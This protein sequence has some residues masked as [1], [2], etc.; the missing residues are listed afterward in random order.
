VVAPGIYPTPGVVQ[1]IRECH[2]GT[3]G[4]FLGPQ[5]VVTGK[6]MGEILPVTDLQVLLDRDLIVIDELIGKGIGIDP[7]P[8]NGQ[9]EKE[10]EVLL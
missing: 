1:E 2:Q 7:S 9:E 4:I 5:V 3:E 8:D 10:E 6:K